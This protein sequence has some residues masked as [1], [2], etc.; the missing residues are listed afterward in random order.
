M[1]N[2]INR[3]NSIVM[4]KLNQKNKEIKLTQINNLKKLNIY[5]L[6][7]NLVDRQSHRV[8]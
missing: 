3:E 1:Q 7:Q 4:K 8:T 6:C 2:V 5:E